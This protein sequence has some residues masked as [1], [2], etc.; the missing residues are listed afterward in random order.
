M[1]SVCL[2]S[3]CDPFFFNAPE[4][5]EIYTCEHCGESI[6]EGDEYVDVDGDYY[7]DE[8]FMDCSAEILL[9]K[10]G[11]VKGIAEADR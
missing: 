11:A 3:P 5:K 10:Y 9:E 2:K 1:C 6:V 4:P 7:H 8:C